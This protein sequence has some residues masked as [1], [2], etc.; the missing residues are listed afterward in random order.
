MLGKIILCSLLLAQQP[1]GA[2]GA[3]SPALPRPEDVFTIAA[4]P[5]ANNF[6]PYFTA[7]SLLRQLPDFRAG[8]PEIKVGAKRWWQSGV[9]VLKDRRVIFWRTCRS[10]FIILEAEGGK[11]AS[12]ILGGGKDDL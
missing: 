10:N 9:I 5:D 3:P 12:Y 1:V 8:E 6:K 4:R 2:G 11:T 7:E